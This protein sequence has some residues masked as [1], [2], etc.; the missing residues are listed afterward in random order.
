ME[1]CRARVGSYMCQT[2]WAQAWPDWPSCSVP[3]QTQGGELHLGE[4]LEAHPP[5]VSEI[6]NFC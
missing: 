1:L 2:L 3:T 5:L 6:W 4:V